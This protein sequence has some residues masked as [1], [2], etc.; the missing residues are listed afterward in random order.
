MKYE[1]ALMLGNTP[2]VIPVDLPKKITSSPPPSQIKGNNSRKIA[3][4]KT[5][6]TS[7]QRFVLQK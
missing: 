2:T 3:W 1:T 4:E 7:M 6:E 5:P